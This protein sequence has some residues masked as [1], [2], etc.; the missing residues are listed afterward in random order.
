[1]S[2]YKTNPIGICEL[3][4]MR[5]SSQWHHKFSQTKQNRER[6][7]KLLDERFNLCK[8]CKECN[9]SHAHIPA[10]A[11]WD[12]YNFRMNAERQGFILPKKLRSCK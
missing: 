12:E 2:K 6:Y 1:M 8:S 9:V 5:S 4:N 11:K 7:G 10:W 3:C